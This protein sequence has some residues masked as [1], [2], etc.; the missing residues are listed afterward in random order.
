MMASAGSRE[1]LARILYARSARLQTGILWE[2]L[3]ESAR[4]PWFELAGQIVADL[5]G[6]GTPEPD[7]YDSG[8]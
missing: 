2:R 1:Q 7:R 3:G 4:Q 8:L 6:T 5:A